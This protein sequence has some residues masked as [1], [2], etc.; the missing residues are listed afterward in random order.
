M[1]KDGLALRLR[2]RRYESDFKLD[3]PRRVPHADLVKAVPDMATLSVIRGAILS[4]NSPR[5]APHADLV[6]AFRHGHIVP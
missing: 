5:R 3:S 2:I 1:P 6:R 4:L